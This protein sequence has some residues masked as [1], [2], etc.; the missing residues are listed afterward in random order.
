MGGALGGSSSSVMPTTPPAYTGGS[1]FDYTAPLF[2]ASPV[3]QGGYDWNAALYG[4]GQ[5][6]KGAGKGFS[7]GT[8]YVPQPYQPPYMQQQQLPSGQVQ[9]TQIPAQTQLFDALIRLLSGGG[10][11][12][13]SAGSYY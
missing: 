12:S 2:S 6:L 10:G 4:I 7:G 8:G 11:A 13:G 1:V 9:V 3:Q 5:G